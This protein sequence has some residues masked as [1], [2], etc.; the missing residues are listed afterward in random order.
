MT[1][2]I[3]ALTLFVLPPAALPGCQERCELA[4][5]ASPCRV[6]TDADD[7]FPLVFLKE[8]HGGPTAAERARLV[9]D[10]Q[11]RRLRRNKANIAKHKRLQAKLQRRRARHLQA[12]E[13]RHAREMNAASCGLCGNAVERWRLRKPKSISTC[14]DC[15]VP[16]AAKTIYREGSGF[17]GDIVPDDLRDVLRACAVALWHLKHPDWSPP[18]RPR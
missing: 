6:D 9:A 18:W 8:K 12:E 4:A 10:W 1:E 13:R 5:Y 17:T 14:W 7:P 11:E 2:I 16:V 15:E 3:Y